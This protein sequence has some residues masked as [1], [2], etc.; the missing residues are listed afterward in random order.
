MDTSYLDK[1]LTPLVEPASMVKLI[2]TGFGKFN[3]VESNPSE[4]LVK[5]LADAQKDAENGCDGHSPTFQV[6]EVSA[7]YVQLALKSLA[8]RADPSAH[9]VW[10]HFGVHGTAS[11]FKLER[12]AFNDANF[13]V[14]DQAGWQPHDQAID[15]AHSL[16]HTLQTDLPV[17]ELAGA[18]QKHIVAVSSDAGRFVCNYTLYQSLRQCQQQHG[19]RWQAVFVHVPPFTVIS[20]DR[21][22]AFAKDLLQLLSVQPAETAGTDGVSGSNSSSSSDTTLVHEPKQHRSPVLGSLLGCLPCSK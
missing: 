14:P 1:N 20:Q 6:M 19:G 18:L 3:G 11:T 10:V 9:T 5:Q 15:P 8:K 12:Q 7:E 2:V 16:Q 17:N 21:Q 13:R 22:L 4:W